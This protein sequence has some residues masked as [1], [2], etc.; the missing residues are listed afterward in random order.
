MANRNCKAVSDLLWIN[1]W[2][3]SVNT[4]AKSNCKTGKDLLCINWWES[5]E[6]Q[7]RIVT[8]RLG[9]I[10]CVSTGGNHQLRV[11]LIAHPHHPPTQD[12][13]GSR[14]PN[15]WRTAPGGYPLKNQRRIVTGYQ[16]DYGLFVWMS[17]IQSNLL[18]PFGNLTLKC[19][20]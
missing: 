16:N 2:E 14:S 10:Y 20:I 9:R 12:W 19:S 1:W 15:H 17:L 13:L 11:L 5:S 4:E 3:S 6:K 18:R 7:R 8:V